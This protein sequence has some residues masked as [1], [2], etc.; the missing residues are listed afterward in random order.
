MERV[1]T[2]EVRAMTSRI[3]TRSW[4]GIAATALLVAGVPP[5]FAQGAGG[6]YGGA[7]GGRDTARTANRSTTTGRRR[8]TAARRIRVSKEQ[9][10]TATGALATPPRDT[11]TVRR[12]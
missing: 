6:A 7:G 8:T 4:L 3:R 9:T 5:T 12:D 1:T 10:D 11:T 2:T